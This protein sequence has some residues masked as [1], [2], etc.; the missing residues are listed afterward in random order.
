M[1]LLI[2]KIIP[3]FVLDFYHLLIA[4]GANLYYGFPSRKMMIIG[5]TGTDGKTTTCNLIYNILRQAGLKVGLVSTVYA[6]IGD[7]EIDTGFHTTTPDSWFLQRLLKK[8]GTEGIEQF[9]ARIV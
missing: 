2:R 1:K 6:K 5:V 3:Q 4:L 8:M 9:T 7:R